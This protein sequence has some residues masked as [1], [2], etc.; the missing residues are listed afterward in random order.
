[1]LDSHPDMAIP[2]EAQFLAPMAKNRR[3]YERK[4]FSTERFVHDLGRSPEF[5]GW[6]LPIQEVRGMFAEHTP[7]DFSEA[8]RGVYALYAHTFGKPRYGDKTPRNVF[9]MTTLPVVLGRPGR[10]GIALEAVGSSG[11]SGTCPARSRELH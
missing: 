1:M 3:R 5:R 8:I 10:S 9:A 6:R 7:R 4:R 2:G 11:T